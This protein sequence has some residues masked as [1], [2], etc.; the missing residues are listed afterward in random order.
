MVRP[1]VT[2]MRVSSDA[3]GQSSTVMV[4][5]ET[6]HADEE[7]LVVCAAA[8]ATSAADTPLRTF[9]ATEYVY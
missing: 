8:P 4:V 6:G 9:I 7:G 1:C 5:Y 2:V 3:L